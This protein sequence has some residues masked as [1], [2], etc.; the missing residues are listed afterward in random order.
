MSNSQGVTLAKCFDAVSKTGGEINSLCET[1]ENLM[2]STFQSSELVSWV[3]D[4][5]S[6]SALDES[7]WL[8]SDYIW[9]LPIGPQK[10]S[11]RKIVVGYQISLLG[12]G[13]EIDSKTDR[14]ALIHI[15]KFP[16]CNI[17]FNSSNHI[18]FPYP[19]N[20]CGKVTERRLVEWPLENVEWSG[21]S[22]QW[23]YSLKLVQ[24]NNKK[25]LETCVINPVISLIQ[26]KPVLDAIPQ[27]LPGLVFYDESSVFLNT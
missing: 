5:L 11:R 22:T 17:G 2:T 9:G 27:N 16:D 19:G 13:T 6:D 15:F 21:S 7:N 10:N 8:Y 20:E 14:E 25:D 23:F 12:T 4:P 1:L 18:G 3:G 26:G 24:I